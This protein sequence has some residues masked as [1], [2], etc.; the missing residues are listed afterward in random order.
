MF[1]ITIVVK[2]CFCLRL[3]VQVKKVSHLVFGV[4]DFCNLER[5]KTED[6][7]GTKEMT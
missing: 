4:G 5:K 3:Y 2:I 6:A 7:K 1:Q